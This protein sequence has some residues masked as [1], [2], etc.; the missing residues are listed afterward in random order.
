M[1]DI[2]A[3]AY[4]LTIAKGEEKQH[5]EDG[6]M[7]ICHVFANA[8]NLQ[9]GDKFTIG[10][11]NGKTYT[12]SAI[13]NTPEC[14]SGF[15]DNYLCYVNSKTLSRM[16]GLKTYGIHMYAKSD[17]VTIKAINETL[18]EAYKSKLIASID[19][20]TLKMCL[21]ILSGIFGGVGV[22]AALLILGV[23]II[24]IRYMIRAVIDKEY[25]MIG[26]YKAIGRSNFEIKTIYLVSYM[27]VGISGMVLGLLLGRPLAIY[28]ANVILSNMKGFQLSVITNWISVFV[29]LIMGG[30]LAFHIWRELRKINRITPIQAMTV[31]IK[32]TK[33]KIC[34]SVIKNA[35]SAASMAFNRMFKEKSM[36]LLVILVL[37][38]S[39]YTCLMVSAVGLSLGNYSDDREIWENL[40]DYDGYIKVANQEEVTEYLK[41]SDDIK[42][43]VAMNL[44]I[45]NVEMKFEDCDITRNEA[46]PMVYSNFTAER[47]TNVPFT[48][49]RICT[50]PHEITV[51]DK[52]L[53]RTDH[54]VGDYMTISINNKKI[55][56][57]IVGSY[58]AMMRGGISFYIQEQDLVEAG[59]TPDLSTVLFFLKDHIS[60]EKFE[61]DFKAHFTDSKIYKD[62]KFIE[63]EERTVNEIAVP[64]CIVIFAAFSA[65]SILNIINV[66]YTQNHENRR[67]YG[68]LK[69]MGFT[70]GYLCRETMLS[71]TMESVV[72]IFITV[73][74][75]E[76][77]SPVIFS[78]ASGIRYIYK[79]IWLTV[80][81]CVGIYLIIMMITMIM[82]LTIRKI[83]P[84]ELMEE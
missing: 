42:D 65:F 55:D 84:V 18:P 22:G 83:T 14:S 43:Y 69:A 72:A 74:L 70:T 51:S 39:F 63:Q 73:I 3:L 57:L 2:S 67:K 27:T 38:V 31:G 49:G 24:V 35:H 32:S 79:P 9:V 7:W 68:I 48:K 40:P 8:A 75:H 66:I 12:I 30:L 62:F 28:L 71:L 17:D 53:T 26:I 20:N 59:V 80:I 45:E 44:S 10:E 23:S 4:S 76:I 47:Y 16:S 82:L 56:F 52:F 54:A 25:H 1:D 46:N 64:I 81:V 34:K 15:I 61:K 58:S 78:L 29:I 41:N 21:S 77:L 37:A 6:E 60:Y 33:K 50:N 19:A 5:P 13:V 11:K 36:T